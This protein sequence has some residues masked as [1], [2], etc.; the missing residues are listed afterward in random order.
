[1]EFIGRC[2][3]PPS[4]VVQNSSAS[5]IWHAMGLSIYQSSCFK[6]VEI[7]ECRKKQ[8]S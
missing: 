5:G 7:P 3:E 6:E 1:M 2:Q 4:S 8:V